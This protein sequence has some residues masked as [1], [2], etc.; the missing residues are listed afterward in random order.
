LAKLG[1]Q[2]DRAFA[3]LMENKEKMRE[4]SSGGLPGNGGERGEES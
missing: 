4:K 1:G 3:D 2:E